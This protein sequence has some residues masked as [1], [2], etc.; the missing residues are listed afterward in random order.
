M[1]AYLA[2]RVT[3]QLQHY[4]DGPD[5]TFRVESIQNPSLVPRLSG[6]ALLRVRFALKLLARLF[7]LMLNLRNGPLGIHR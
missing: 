1:L 2:S 6:D 5:V 4:V 3:E 7:A